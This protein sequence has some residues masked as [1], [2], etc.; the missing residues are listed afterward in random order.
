MLYGLNKNTYDD[1]LQKYLSMILTTLIAKSIFLE[2]KSPLFLVL[3]GFQNF[4]FSVVDQFRFYIHQLVEYLKKAQ[5]SFCFCLV[6]NL[7]REEC[8]NGLCGFGHDTSC[9]SREA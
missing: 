9:H 2:K 5:G 7:N 1:L 8:E 6:F 4:M 3:R